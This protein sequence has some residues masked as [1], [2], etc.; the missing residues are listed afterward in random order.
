MES[1][2]KNA[3][4][5]L[6]QNACIHYLIDDLIMKV[7]HLSAEYAHACALNG[8]SLN[9]TLLSVDLLTRKSFGDEVDKCNM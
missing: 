3:I 2:T 5:L 1:Q 8:K 6:S 4:E 7:A 9:A